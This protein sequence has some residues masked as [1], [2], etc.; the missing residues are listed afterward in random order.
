MIIQA[1]TS[2]LKS[3]KLLFILFYCLLISFY[4]HLCLIHISLNELSIKIVVFS[5][6]HIRKYFFFCII[7]IYSDNHKG[8]CLII[9]T[10]I[11]N[12]TSR[13][14]VFVFDVF[15]SLFWTKR[16]WLWRVDSSWSLSVDDTL[17][18]LSELLTVSERNE[19]E[20]VKIEERT[21]L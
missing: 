16:I 19:W 13:F 7:H 1:Y 4:N 11:Y 21:H 12:N 14:F 2:W 5:S 17:A 20:E 15:C 18:V 10:I 8:T 9:V 6:F 3:L